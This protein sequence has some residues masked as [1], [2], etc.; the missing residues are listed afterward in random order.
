MTATA[1][2]ETAEGESHRDFYNRRMKLDTAFTPAAIS[3]SRTCATL[4][5]TVDSLSPSTLFWILLAAAF[6]ATELG[7]TLTLV[8]LSARPMRSGN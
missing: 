8:W 5:G 7:V 1:P 3:L 6:I 2:P 4:L